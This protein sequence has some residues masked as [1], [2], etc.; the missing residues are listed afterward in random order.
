MARAVPA[1][2]IMVS[3]AAMHGQAQQTRISSLEALKNRGDA[4]RDKGDING[5]IRCFR[6][7]VAL[8]PNSGEAHA[9]LGHALSRNDELAEAIAELRKAVGFSPKLASAHFL[10][11]ET[12][13]RTGQIALAVPEYE[14]AAR[15]NPKSSEFRVKYAAAIAKERPRDAIAELR[16]AIE[17]DP[18]SHDAH[19]ALGAVLQRTRDVEGAAL[20]FEYARQVSEASHQRRE[21]DTH[22]NKAIELLNQGHVP[23]AVEK[24]HQAEALAPDFAAPSH[25]RAIALSATGNWEEAREAFRAALRKDPSDPEIHYNF[26]VALKHQGDLKT[27][28][29]EFAKTIGIRSDH[30]PANCALASVLSQMGETKRAEIAARHARALGLCPAPE[31]R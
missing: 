18:G 30:L 4:L 20:E 21:A 5:A 7:V 17:L 8:R 26:G 6:Q 2:F 24:L 11:A 28:A 3:L 1:V 9:D 13:S 12:L 31:A 14:A 15:L 16:K 10:L 25:Y 23:E 29:E 22:T 19:Q 27:A